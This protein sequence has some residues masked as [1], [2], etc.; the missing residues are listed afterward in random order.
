[1]SAG[2]RP[3]TPPRP[4]TDL[5]RV[6]GEARVA[7]SG[8][9]APVAVTGVTHDSRAVL[10]GDLYAALPGFRTHGA[11]FVAQAAAA[12]AV[13]VLTDPAGE[14][15]ALAAG[16]PVLVADDPRSVLGAVASAV[17]G[18]PS[19]DL[20]VVGIT[21]TNGK[22][23]T[24]YLVD[25]G[26]RA[27]GLLTGVIG[28]VGTRVGDEVVPTVRTTPEATDVHALL[29][30]MR[31][32]GVRAVTMEVSSH[33]LRLG[34]VDGVRFDVAAF[35][36]L[37]P[38]HLDFHADMDDYFDA[39]AQLFTA[40]RSDR[41][42]VCVDDEHGVAMA[43][44]ARSNGLPTTTYATASSIA[45]WTAR[46]V[47]TIP[48]GSVL[49][50][51]ADGADIELEVH[52]PGAFNV[53]NGL[54]ALAILTAL[55]IDPVVAARGIGSCPGVPGRMERVPDREPRRGAFGYV[56]YAHTPDAVERALTA[57]R[58][59]AR[60]RPGHTARVIVVL[61]AGGDR[62]PHKRFAMGEAAVRGADRVI[63]TD[64]NPRGED[65][66]EIR[67]EI[68][69]G[70][71]VDPDALV[72][73]IGDRRR[74]IH[75]AASEAGPGDV[76]LILGKGHEQGQEVAGTVTPFDDRVILAEALGPYSDVPAATHE[77]PA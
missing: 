50:A 5:A 68:L 56:D 52:L 57:A 29:A 61:G 62:D 37:S 67:R 44:A 20:L 6:A 72:T 46:D 27:A 47:R 1:M 24:S 77:D 53:A 69:R 45:T 33:A 13:A 66:A 58:E 55:A 43:A 16:L 28:T 21:G 74:A 8:D 15:R 38:D 39:K 41:A 70:A 10:P 18:D 22:T 3:T 25:A 31:E 40:A 63:V 42:V 4:L 14:E 54:G 26:L 11:E 76:V 35:T 59:V 23:T 30:V 75:Q 60:S 34:R 51:V 32:R 64:D 9:P 48:G 36:N 71:A 65:P 19:H 17:Y 49:H 7:G 73:E 12:G 2:P